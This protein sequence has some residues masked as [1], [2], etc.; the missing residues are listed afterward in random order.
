MKNAG[1]NI[2]NAQQN[3]NTLLHLAV[4]KDDLALINKAIELGIDINAQDEEGNTALHKAALTA[5]N[6]K[7]LAKLI[8][9][10]VN[11]DLKTEFDETAYDLANQNDFLKSNNVN[12]DFLK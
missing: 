7:V 12:I 5:K 6:D 2:S 1:F 4:E 3:G 11:K 10:G 8:Q 9:L